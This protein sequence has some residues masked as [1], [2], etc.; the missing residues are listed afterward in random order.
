MI[1]LSSLGYDEAQVAV[2]AAIAEC[3][4]RGC[5][6]VIAVADVFGELL[7]LARMDGAPSNSV[8]IAA[9]KAFTAAQTKSASKTIGA[10]ARHPETGFDL[11]YFGDPRFIGWGGGLPVECNGVCVGSVALSGLP[12][13]EDIEIAAI[14]VAAL[15][16]HL[17]P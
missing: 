11:A 1:S 6:A 17:Q 14:A 16:D 10:A 8:R 9:N 2:A 4:R 13:S 12:E 3:E 7:A 5:A 15:Q